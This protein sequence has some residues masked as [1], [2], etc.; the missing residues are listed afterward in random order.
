MSEFY[1]PLVE[2]YVNCIRQRL[3]EVESGSKEG[4]DKE[5]AKKKKGE[6]W[7]AWNK[8][9]VKENKGN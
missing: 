7:T 2:K 6:V 5:Q 3:Q 1:H 9:T 4:S 8:G